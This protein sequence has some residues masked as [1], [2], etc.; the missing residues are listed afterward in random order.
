MALSRCA[1]RRRRGFTLIELLVVIAIIAVLIGLLLPAVQKVREAAARMSCSNNLKQ[2]G[3]ATHNINDTSHK[4]PPVYGWFPSVSN[5]PQSNAAYGSVL[6][7]LLPYI[8]QQNLYSASYGTYNV[9]GVTVQAYIPSLNSAVSSTPV[10]TFQ[11]PSDPSMAEGHPYGMAEGGSSYACNF[12]AFGAASGTYPVASWSWFG[13][14][15]IPASFLDG[16]SNTVLFTEKY[17][18]C[19]YPPLKQTGGGTMWVHTSYNSGQSWWPVVMSPDYIKYSPQCYGPNPGALFLV[20]PR[21]FIGN[22]DWTRASTGHTGGINVGLADGSVRFVS[23]GVS[24]TTWWFAF[25]PN[26]GEVLGG[27]W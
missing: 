6:V 1:P 23:Q 17:A 16:T 4:L 7:H 15:S 20:Q 3:L 2:L 19:E 24:Y 10:K 25:T 22:C 26:G 18:R 11:C 9:G 8:E 14:N 27:D 21:P 5:T 13:T 12:F